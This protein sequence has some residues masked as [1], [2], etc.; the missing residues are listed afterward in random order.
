MRLTKDHV[1]KVR[2]SVNDQEALALLA[3]HYG[4][5]RSWVLRHLIKRA[6]SRLRVRN[7]GVGVRA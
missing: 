2:L 7:G 1:H 5:T 3:Q 6:A 4:R